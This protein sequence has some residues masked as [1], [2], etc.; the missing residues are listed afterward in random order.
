MLV[1]SVQR[2]DVIKRI[3][4][5][6]YVPQLFMSKYFLLNGG[7]S[8]AYR[9]IYSMLTGCEVYSNFSTGFYWGW[10]QNPYLR[11]H[12]FDYIRSRLRMSGVFLDI[13]DS[14]KVVIMD[15]DRYM[16]FVDD[17]RLDFPVVEL[18]DV[19]RDACLQ[20]SFLEF[21][22]KWVRCVVPLDKLVTLKEK[23]IEGIYESVRLDDVSFMYRPSLWIPCACS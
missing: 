21:N 18:G 20:A 7:Y 5:R 2:D 8:T 23:S 14:E 9:T 17:I 19:P 15:Y 16:E 13:P 1:L 10:V 3:F 11:M 6:K 12:T 4:E 22:P